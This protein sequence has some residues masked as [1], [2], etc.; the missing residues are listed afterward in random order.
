[1]WQGAD[2]L[3]RIKEAE[4][5]RPSVSDPTNVPALPKSQSGDMATQFETLGLDSMDLY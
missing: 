3:K 1:M 4:P 2:R 5:F